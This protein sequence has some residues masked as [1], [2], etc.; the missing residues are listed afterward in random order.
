MSETKSL[1]HEDFVLWSKQQAAALRAAARA[2]TD[3]PIDWENVAEEIE[4]LGKTD[5][6]TL[7]SQVRRIVLHLIKLEHSPAIGPRRG[8]R[9]SI[10]DA[11]TQI[12]DLL[13]DSPSLRRE[14]LE[15]I[16]REIERGARLALADLADRGELDGSLAEALRAESYLELFAYTEEQVLGDWFPPEPQEAPRGE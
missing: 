3:Q 14:T 13:D 1:Y 4:D 5:R 16:R 6:R 15:I 11:R 8:W 10:R 12:E 7:H 9:E 2:G